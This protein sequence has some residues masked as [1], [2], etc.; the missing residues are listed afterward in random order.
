MLTG[1]S[2]VAQVV[3]VLALHA[4][5]PIWVPVLSWQPRFPSSSLP[6]AWESSRGRPKAL[7]PCTGVGDLEKALDSR[8]WIGSAPVIA[9]G[10][11]VNHWMEDLAFC[12]SS[13]LYI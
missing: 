7:G 4:Q 11:G 2:A 3:K 5:D 6:V 1:P 10:W 8:L 13:S 12:L 9:A